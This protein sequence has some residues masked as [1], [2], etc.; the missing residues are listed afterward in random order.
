MKSTNPNLSFWVKA[1][2]IILMF[3][4]I[5]LTNASAQNYKPYNEALAAVV[6]AIDGLK[7]S[8]AITEVVTNSTHANATAKSQNSQLKVFEISYFGIFL[9]KAKESGDV[10]LAVQA[11]DAFFS[12]QGQPQSR[13]TILNAARGDLMHLITY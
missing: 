13:V 3:L 7:A 9:D 6:N 12:S 4:G 2:P 8:P 11:L 10:A 5:G 1:F